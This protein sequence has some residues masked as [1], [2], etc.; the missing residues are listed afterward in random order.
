MSDPSFKLLA[1]LK[2]DL[3]RK[4][5]L[6]HGGG[7]TPSTRSLLGGA[8]DPRFAPVFLCRLAYWFACHGLRPI[9]KALSLCNLVIFGIEIGLRCR[10]GGG[11]VLPHT[12][13]T[14]IGAA[15]IGVNATIFQG[16]TLGAKGL[17]IVFDE[18]QRPILGDGVMVGSG[19]KVLGGIRV[20]NNVKIG[21]NAVVLCSLPDEVVAVGVPA[22]FALRS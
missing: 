10:I 16:A 4:W 9:G 8:F 21:A 13:G 22:T 12:H 7:Q 1:H 5:A 20:G 19:A 18:S 17:D 11:L 3:S 2:A 6:I 14:V 15:S